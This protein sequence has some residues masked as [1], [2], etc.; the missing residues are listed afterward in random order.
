MKKTA[1]QHTVVIDMSADE[2]PVP[3][4]SGRLPAIL[5]LLALL[6]TVTVAGLAYVYWQNLQQNLAQMTAR[7]KAAGEVQRALQQSIEQAQ[8]ALQAQQRL[9]NRQTGQTSQQRDTLTDYKRAFRKQSD[10]LTAERNRM[11]QREVE[12]RAII[13]DLR[14]RL[15]KPDKRWMVAEAE[16][17][18]QLALQ[19]L[20]L[21]DDV[22]TAL[23]ALQQADQRLE[24]TGDAQWLVV[25]RRL[26][27]DMAT[28]KQAR[29]P[30]ITAVLRQM[31][32]MSADFSRL[33]P[34]LVVEE[35]AADRPSQEPPATADGSPGLRD[36]GQD[37]WDGLKR[38]VRIRRHDRPVASLLSQGQEVVLVQNAI[39]LLETARLALVQKDPVLYQDSLQRLSAWL[40]RHFHMQDVVGE[41]V[42]QE[43][44]ALQ[45]VDLKP[46][47]PDLTL[48]LKALQTRRALAASQDNGGVTE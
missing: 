31:D 39:L 27:E 33:K 44:L 46:E 10:L 9:L 43:I 20:Q 11:Q 28:L 48:A 34:R 14:N 26:A 21:A 24:E 12:L 40:K 35:K 45:K 15:G 8:K 18:V 19:R 29:L 25:R 13:A 3:R 47:Y 41:Q 17:L 23:A 5:A 6:V 38:S 30:D 1:E 16:Y 2:L 22:G 42:E 4:P 32:V 36:L 37:L 7:A